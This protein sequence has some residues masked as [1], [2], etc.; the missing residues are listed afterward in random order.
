MV[1]PLKSD[2]SID[3]VLNGFTNDFYVNVKIFCI[4]YFKECHINCL[5]CS[6]LDMNICYSC[7]AGY[8]L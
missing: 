3:V 5:N 7:H 2:K 6:K 8:Y 4:S 1:I